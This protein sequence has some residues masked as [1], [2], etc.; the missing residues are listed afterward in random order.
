MEL[1]LLDLCFNAHKAM[2]TGG[3]LTLAAERCSFDPKAAEEIHKGM[4]AGE[5]VCIEVAD[6]G[7][8]ITP[9]QMKRLFERGESNWGSGKGHGIGLWLLKQV[10]TDL[11][12]YV[13]DPKSVVGK[14]TTFRIYLPAVRVATG[15]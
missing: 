15:T 12:G 6:T 10:I 9:E 11:G 14:G 5:Y 7:C 4:P 3:K 1:L 13:P 2:P 8:G